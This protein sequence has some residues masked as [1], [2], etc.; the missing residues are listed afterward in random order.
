VS[1]GSSINVALP[2]QAVFFDFGGVLTTPV[3]DTITAWLDRDGIDPATFSRVL[4]EWLGRSA[5]QGTP[6]HLLET[7]AISAPEFDALLGAE[8]RYLDGGPVASEG[9]L[10]GLFAEMLPDEGMFSLVS[11][12][13][14]SGVQV[15][16][17]SNSW[18]NTYPRER[19][20][21]LFDS[22]VIS[23][24]V[25]MR[26]PDADIYEFAL[27][28]LGVEPGRA[29]FID[30]AEPNTQGAERVGMMAVHHRAEVST[31]ERLRQLG[32]AVD[33]AAEM[34]A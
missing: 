5:R 16:L 4:K 15:G 12:I 6:I 3:A 28:S 19:I 13:K 30:D 31:R 7:G 22:I 25:G 11:E 14:A 26:K 18:G 32:L 10:R 29:V 20:D 34:K 24:E 27:A 1:D 9:L 23:G 8:L 21:L 2:V 33:A 17:L